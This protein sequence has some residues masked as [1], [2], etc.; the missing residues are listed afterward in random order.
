VS[1][2]VA[3]ESGIMVDEPGLAALARVEVD[4]VEAEAIDGGID[5]ISTRVPEGQ[6]RDH[7]VRRIRV[8]CGHVR[9][10]AT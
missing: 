10:R 4:E 7:V 5:R 2:E 1:I 9:A 8:R 3:N 6:L